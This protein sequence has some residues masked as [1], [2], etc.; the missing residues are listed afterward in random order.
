MDTDGVQTGF[1]CELTRSVAA[2]TSVPVVASGGA[3]EPED[4][5]EVL[6]T[7]HA[8]AA[9]AASVFHYGKYTVGD[10]KRELAAAQYTG[11]SGGSSMIFPCIDILD[12][13]VVQ[14]VQGRETALEGGSADEML[15]LFR[16]FPEIQV[17]DLNSAMGN[18]ANNNQMVEYISQRVKSRVGGGVRSVERAKELNPVRRS[19][20]DC[21]HLCVSVQRLEH[22]FS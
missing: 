20:A 7:G 17:I 18:G 4:F 21:G 6:T 8:D 12:G 5:I 16:A 2:A 1:D 11:A 3:G 22:A 14:L 9:L 19:P 15:R 10:L 13:K